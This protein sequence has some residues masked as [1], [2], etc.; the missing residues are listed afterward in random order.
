MTGPLEW[1]ESGGPP[2]VAPRRTGFGAR[3]IERGR[4]HELGGETNGE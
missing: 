4:A 2:V 3:L 1:R